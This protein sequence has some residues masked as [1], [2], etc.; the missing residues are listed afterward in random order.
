MTLRVNIEDSYGS[1]LRKDAV[2]NPH[3]L[4]G[5]G[6]LYFIERYKDSISISNTGISC[7]DSF[8]IHM[9]NNLTDYVKDG[10]ITISLAVPRHRD[11]TNK[12]EGYIKEY[13][14]I[15][16]F[17]EIEFSLFNDD[18]EAL[19]R[20]YVPKGRY[21]IVLKE[22]YELLD[23]HLLDIKI[24][25]QL[26]ADVS[27]IWTLTWELR[28]ILLGFGSKTDYIEFRKAYLKLLT[29]KY[30]DIILT[31]NTKLILETWKLYEQNSSGVPIVQWNG[32]Y[33]IYM[34]NNKLKKSKKDSDAFVDI[35]NLHHKYLDADL[36]VSSIDQK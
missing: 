8:F 22:E 15:P 17:K 26:F 19:K 14:S 3:S 13:S 35:F 34:W 36:L 11:L 31:T 30:N 24:P 9:Q 2:F 28:H 7:R 29:D 32:P 23:F 33:G 20:I 5:T 4:W 6:G 12:L 25:I 21:D 16:Y 1:P 18:I 10:F 27:I